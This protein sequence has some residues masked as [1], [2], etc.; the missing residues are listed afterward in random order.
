M[1][2]KPMVDNVDFEKKTGGIPEKPP[3]SHGSWEAQRGNPG[4]EICSWLR[5]S[6]AEREEYICRTS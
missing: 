6:S 3:K 5:E 2:R 1:L 4:L